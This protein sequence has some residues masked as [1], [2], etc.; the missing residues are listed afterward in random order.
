[1]F[2]EV[3]NHEHYY[4]VRENGKY[5]IGIYPVL[6]GFRVRIWEIDSPVCTNDLCFGDNSLNVSVG[7]TT[8]K[9][10]IES[11]GNPNDIPFQERKPWTVDSIMSEDTDFNN[12]M[13]ENVNSSK[14][15]KEDYEDITQDMLMSYRTTEFQEI[16]NK[17]FEKA[18]L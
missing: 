16:R 18:G 17:E 12:W 14:T 13:I 6:F 4:H 2:K 5:G 3:E 10:F 9:K 11:G 15:T 1:M 7:Y 8:I